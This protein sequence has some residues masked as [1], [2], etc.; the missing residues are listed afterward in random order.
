MAAL[1]AWHL[2]ACGQQALRLLDEAHWY[3]YATSASE[4]VLL[5]LLSRSLSRR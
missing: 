2:L 5:T 4:T 3:A 1:A